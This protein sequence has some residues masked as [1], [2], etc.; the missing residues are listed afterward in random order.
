MTND[1]SNQ[2]FAYFK[3]FSDNAFRAQSV[4]LQAAEQVAGL[5]LQAFEKQA[6]QSSAF[7]AEAMEA[8]DMDAVRG[9]WEK[10]AQLSRENAERAVNVSQEVYSMTQKTAESLSAMAQQQQ[11]AANDAVATP[12]VS[13]KKASAK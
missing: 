11:Q 6:E 10:G 3:Q 5:Q 9:L 7:F 4:A 8:R 2:A 12:G 1:Y 13:G